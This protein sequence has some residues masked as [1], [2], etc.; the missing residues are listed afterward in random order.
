ME[1]TRHSLEKARRP[2]LTRVRKMVSI[3]LTTAMIGDSVRRALQGPPG[4]YTYRVSLPVQLYANLCVWIDQRVPWHKLPVP[5][6][7]AVM[8]GDRI[9][10][11]EANLHDTSGYPTLPQ[12]EPQATGIESPSQ[13]TPD[14]TF[15]DLRAPSM[16]AAG[17]R[18]GRNVPTEFTWPDPEP[19]IL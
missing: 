17:T 7:L 11:R 18:F 9:K 15:N 13:R 2:K 6:A 4:P 14:G 8:I 16:G 19:K 3:L 12:P 1:R 10:L 5:L